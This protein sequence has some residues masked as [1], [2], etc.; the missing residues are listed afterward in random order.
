MRKMMMVFAA[1]FCMLQLKAQIKNLSGTWEGVLN[2]GRPLNIVYN[3]YRNND[4]AYGGTMDVPAQN[5]KGLIVNKVTVKGDSVIAELTSAGI[6]YK[7]MFTRDSTLNG[8]WLQNG[9]S[10]PLVLKLTQQQQAA[11]VIRPQ[12]PVP[13]FSYNSEDVEYDNPDK[14]VH[15]G[16]TLT[17]P[18][19]G[20]SFPTALLITGSGQQD[21]D[22]TIFGHK[23]FAV[24]AD[25][26]TKKGYAVLRVDDRI[27]GKTTGTLTNVTSADFAKDVEAGIAYLKTRSEVDKNKI[28]LIGHS[29]GGAIAPMVAAIHPD[30]YFIILWAGPIAGGLKINVEQNGYALE[31]AGI[32]NTSVN[33]FKQLHAKELALFE[34]CA[35]VTALNIQVKKVYDTWKQQQPEVVLK[36]L[37]ANDSTILTKNI[38]AIYDNLYSLAWM[39]FFIM[40]SFAADLAKVHCKVLAINGDMDT[41]VDAAMNLHV[42]DSTLTKNNNHHFKTV[43]LKGLNHL[44]QPATTGDTSEYATIQITIA[45][46]A[47][48]TIGDWM[49]ENVMN[50]K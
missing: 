35:D 36:N 28:G 1:L 30:L 47:L 33:A 10:L 18:K 4:S 38:Y 27:I 26:L 39:R 49:D 12:T 14:T 21:R 6:T 34:K 24:L 41:Q 13:P 29:E 44:L 11:E 19:T 43:T 40:H 9:A 31:Q 48:K 22:E 37:Y 17:F 42:I 5:A 23:P 2:I 46:E 45:P 7:G 20:S 3:F 50:K 8:K 16:G 25:Y 15:F 32:D